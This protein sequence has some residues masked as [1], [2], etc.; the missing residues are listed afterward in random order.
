[1]HRFLS[2][3]LTTNPCFPRARCVVIAGLAACS[4]LAPA[5]PLWAD[6]ALDDDDVETAD[7][8]PFQ[9]DAG[10]PAGKEAPDAASLTVPPVFEELFPIR[11]K[12]LR[13]LSS[14]H[15]EV[16]RRALRRMHHMASEL[17]DLKLTNMEEFTRRMDALRLEGHAEQIAAKFRESKDPSEQGVLEHEMR[18]TLEKLFDKKEE[19]QRA[20]VARME[21][22]VIALKKKLAAKHALRDKAITKRLAELKE[23]DE[24]LDF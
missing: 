14:T 1:M 3:L 13:D 22:E 2:R 12:K 24:D 21:H 19:T 7:A 11:V 4:L 16:Y 23:E 6:H 5:A 9:H 8:R 17:R 18:T 10:H 15:P 20:H